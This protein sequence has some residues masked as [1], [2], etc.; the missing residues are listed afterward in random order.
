MNLIDE[1]LS[2]PDGNRPK[3]SY[4]GICFTGLIIVLAREVVISLRT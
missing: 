2:W 3:V 1:G 4:L